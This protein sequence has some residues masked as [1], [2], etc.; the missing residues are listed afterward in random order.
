[1][2]GGKRRDLGGV[3]P[4]HGFSCRKELLQEDCNVLFLQTKKA[5]CVLIKRIQQRPRVCLQQFPQGCGQ[6]RSDTGSLTARMI[7]DTHTGTVIQ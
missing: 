5:F 7:T 2:E 6:P 4:A 3:R 1:M